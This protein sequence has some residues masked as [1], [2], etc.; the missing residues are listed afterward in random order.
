MKKSIINE[1]KQHVRDL[2]AD[3]VINADNIEDAHFH[4]FG[5]DYYIIG[6][7]NAEQWLEKH[8]INAW[9][10]IQYVIEQDLE[11]FGEITLTAGDF[12]AETIVNL[13]AYYTGMELN[14]NDMLKGE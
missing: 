4:A 1:L 10:A 11:T 12:N 14:F 13:V 7:W 9:S 3:G 2:I 6:Y 8:H 5:E